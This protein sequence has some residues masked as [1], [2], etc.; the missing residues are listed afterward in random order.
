MAQRSDWTFEYG[1]E[2]VKDA[3]EK[4]VQ[5]HAD[6]ITFWESAKETTLNLIRESGIDIRE[7][8]ITGGQ[9]AEVIIDPTHQ[10]RLNEAQDGLTRNKAKLDEYEGWAQVLHS[11]VMQNDARTLS[12]DHQDILYFGLHHLNA[13]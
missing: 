12:L 8:E 5:F 6:R 3:A 4:K 13:D 7:H 1:I 11:R 9:R 2:E 10:Q